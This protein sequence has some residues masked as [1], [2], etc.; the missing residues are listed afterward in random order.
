MS[1]VLLQKLPNPFIMDNNK[2]VSTT[3]EW[4]LRRGE[5]KKSLIDICYGGT[6]PPPDFTEG[7]L[8]HASGNGGLETYLITT[9]FKDRKISFELRLYAPIPEKGKVYP[10]VLDG[11]GCWPTMSEKVIDTFIRRKIIIAQFNRCSLVRDVDDINEVLNSPLYH[12]F[13]G[14]DFGS[15]S[16]WAWGFSRCIDVLEKLPFTDKGNIAITGHSRGGKAV[17]LAGAVDER[18]LVINPNCSGAGGCGCWRYRAGDNNRNSGERS[19]VLSDLLRAFPNWLGKKMKDY[20]DRESLLP[21]DQHYL[22]A[23]A[24]PRYFL[25]TDAAADIWAN[26]QG[27]YGTLL[28]AR[29]VYRFLGAEDHLLCNFR[30]GLHDHTPE[31]FEILADLIECIRNGLAPAKNLQRDFYPE[32]REIFDWQSP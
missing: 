1:G 12:L 14:S 9:G 27:S 13:P 28:A 24:A 21:F 15:L 7:K 5:I 20:Q 11:D 25:Q 6:P 30:E 16:G 26:P 29:E 31:D 2:A 23:L 18:P 4:L 3:E 10:V 8:L 22:K 32:M 19:E 17:M